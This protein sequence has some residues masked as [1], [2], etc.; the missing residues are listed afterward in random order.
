MMC[1][2]I[3]HGFAKADA[4]S[5]SDCI[6][7]QGFR[8]GSGLSLSRIHSTHKHTMK[9]IGLSKYG[10]QV[11]NVLH[12]APPARLYQDAIIHEKGSAIS[13]SGAL[14]AYSGKKTGRSPQDKRVVRHS[15]VSS[16]ESSGSLQNSVSWCIS[17]FFA[18]TGSVVT[19]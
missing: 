10:I 11:Q 3:M 8:K 14:I 16:P 4:G 5:T 6:S 12:N 15:R 7:R 1:A 19:R 9:T 17:Y 18:I 2:E 13:D